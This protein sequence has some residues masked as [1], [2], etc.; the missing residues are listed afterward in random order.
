MSTSAHSSRAMVL[1]WTIA[2]IL[3]GNLAWT[4][5]CLGG[6]RPETMVVT[7]ALNGLMLA[8]HL[9]GGA[10]GIVSGRTHLAGW[11]FLPFLAYAA[12]S[13]AWLA[14]VSWLGWDDWLYWAH[15]IAVFWVVL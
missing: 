3:A 8:L 13:A 4:T 2:A 12:V 5:I 7:V 14:P 1:E 10:L 11:W 6:Y 15:M 9:I